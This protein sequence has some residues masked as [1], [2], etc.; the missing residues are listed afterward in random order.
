MVISYQIDMK[1]IINKIL[2]KLFGWQWCSQISGRPSRVGSNI[3]LILTP[4]AQKSIQELM[5]KTE[6]RSVVELFKKTISLYKFLIDHAE[7]GG[8]VIIRSSDGTERIFDPVT[9][10][11]EADEE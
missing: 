10:E 5:D 2:Y 8:K 11:E 3:Q 1:K 4:E 7:E 6:N 9:L